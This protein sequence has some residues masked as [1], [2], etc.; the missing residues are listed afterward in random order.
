MPKIIVLPTAAAPTQLP[1]DTTPSI[2]KRASFEAAMCRQTRGTFPRQHSPEPRPTYTW[3][4]AQQENHIGSTIDHG[5]QG[6]EFAGCRAHNLM[7]SRF[8]CRIYNCWSISCK[9]SCYQA[10]C[11]YSQAKR[12]IICG[13]DGSCRMLIFQQSAHWCDVPCGFMNGTQVKM[14]GFYFLGKS[15]RMM[16]SPRELVRASGRNACP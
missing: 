12:S 6:A 11:C 8:R 9:A 13:F 7:T 14:G 10:K 16:V 4:A 5:T 1:C 2:E 15:K 3:G